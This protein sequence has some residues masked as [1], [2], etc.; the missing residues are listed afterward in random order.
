MA[1]FAIAQSL[2]KHSRPPASGAG[3]P[4]ASP[5]P[6]PRGLSGVS[7]RRHRTAPRSGKRL[8]G[9]HRFDSV[10]AFR[11]AGS[12]RSRHQSVLPGRGRRRP[13][14]APRRPT[15]FRGR[16]ARLWIGGRV[17]RRPVAGGGAG[18]RIPERLARALG[19]EAGLS[20]ERYRSHLYGR[21]Q[22]SALVVPWWEAA[23]SY[24]RQS[25][26]FNAEV[27]CGRGTP[28]RKCAW[29]PLESRIC[30]GTPLLWRDPRS[31]TRRIGGYELQSAL[32]PAACVAG[33]SADGGPGRC[34]EARTGRGARGVRRD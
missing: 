11:R 14:R 32:V 26:L 10:H 27:S 18:G 31:W 6:F 29:K 9:F 17:P 21:D 30:P 15:G 23:A 25:S 1:G 4:D 5:G 7:V 8:A 13:W 3:S 16:R 34:G 19:A 20:G 2:L 24:H 33:W 22:R 28:R 12:R